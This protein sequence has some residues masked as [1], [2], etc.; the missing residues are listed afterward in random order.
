MAE[1][2]SDLIS[3][4]RTIFQLFFFVF[5]CFAIAAAFTFFFLYGLEYGIL[6]IVLGLGYAGVA[7][8][9]FA[10]AYWLIFSVRKSLSTLT[11]I[12]GLIFDT[13]NQ[14]VTDLIDLG[15]GEKRLPPIPQLVDA[16]YE[17][18]FKSI[19]KEA[20]TSTPLVGPLFYWA[21][22]TTIDRMLKIA[23]RAAMAGRKETSEEDK[24]EIEAVIESMPEE[25]KLTTARLIWLRDKVVGSGDWLTRRLMWPFYAA[26]LFLLAVLAVPILGMWFFA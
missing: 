18:V 8:F 6:A 14:V 10:I 9:I 4:P 16:V 3:V 15:K 24:K 22:Q 2:V 19:L 12:V 7:S 17:H 5:S 25:E 13:T 21:Y 1:K 20:I 23:V 26:L 11:E